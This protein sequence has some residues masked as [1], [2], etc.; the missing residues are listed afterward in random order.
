MSDTM[1]IVI[2]GGKFTL[3]EMS[4]RRM[5]QHRGISVTVLFFEIDNRHAGVTNV[6]VAGV[7]RI[8][9][10]QQTAEERDTE[11]LVCKQR[12][13]LIVWGD[14]FIS[15]AVRNMLISEGRKK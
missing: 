9:D 13:A 10:V 8:W 5:H 7:L 11:A 2:C 12:N 4:V 3:V 6:K 1:I 14:N 15:A